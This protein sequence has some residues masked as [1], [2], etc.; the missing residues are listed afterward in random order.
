MESAS[1]PIIEACVSLFQLRDGSKQPTSPTTS[2]D[3]D[4]QNQ[5]HEVLDQNPELVPSL[6]APEANTTHSRP[7]SKATIYRDMPG[8]PPGPI[9]AGALYLVKEPHS[10]S[11]G[12][13]A[14]SGGGYDPTNRSKG[15]SAV[16]QPLTDLANMPYMIALQTTSGA[17]GLAGATP[18]FVETMPMYATA[19]MMPPHAAY[20]VPAHEDN[21]SNNSFA[22]S[23]STTFYYEHP[24]RLL[25]WGCYESAAPLDESANHSAQLGMRR[26]YNYDN[27]A[28]MMTTNIGDNYGGLR[29]QRSS[30]SNDVPDVMTIASLKA[31]GLT[32]V[33]VASTLGVSQSYVSKKLKQKRLADRQLYDDAGG[34]RYGKV[35]RRT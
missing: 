1:Q 8:P 12:V 14:Y 10:V 11:G 19:G 33:Q 27:G 3:T 5:L 32:Q 2:G 17:Y 29:K 15:G 24:R 35:P 21:Y 23:Q 6:P 7:S 18:Q 34:P 4:R 20:Y 31:R 13:N 16:D 26:R 9:S 28:P 22:G 30:A 25:P